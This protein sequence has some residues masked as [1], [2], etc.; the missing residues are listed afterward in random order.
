V[1]ETIA[2]PYCGLGICNPGVI[3]NNELVVDKKDVGTFENHVKVTEKVRV[4]QKRSPGGAGG[5][6][7]HLGPSREYSIQYDY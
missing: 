2:Q 4:W 3:G 5:R 7:R 6:A 1:L